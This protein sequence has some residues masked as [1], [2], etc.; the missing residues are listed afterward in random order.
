MD[1]P[2][3]LA[4]QLEADGE[5]IGHL[6]CACHDLVGPLNAL[7]SI[8]LPQNIQH[9]AARTHVEQLSATAV[10]VKPPNGTQDN[11]VHL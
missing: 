9:N 4:S 8:S 11:R 1:K 3:K 10:C 7:L 5:R 2:P 6:V